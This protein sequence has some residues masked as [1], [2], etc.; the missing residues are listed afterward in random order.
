MCLP[1]HN[2]MFFLYKY[3]TETFLKICFTK[4]RQCFQTETLSLCHQPTIV[5]ELFYYA[6]FCFFPD[7]VFSADCDLWSK[8]W[9]DALVSDS[10]SC[11][12]AIFNTDSPAFKKQRIL[13]DLQTCPSHTPSS[14]R[15]L[16][17]WFFRT[18]CRFLMRLSNGK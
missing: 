3:Y 18:A 5:C 1:F 16:R 11:I 6:V 8:P 4:K 9:S 10:P 7:A 12:A 13:L 14:V 15:Y 2:R 17:L